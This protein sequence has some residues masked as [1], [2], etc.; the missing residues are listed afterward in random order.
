[1]EGKLIVIIYNSAL[2]CPY[3]STY[4]FERQTNNRWPQVNARIKTHPTNSSSNMQKWH[5]SWSFWEKGREKE[6]E[7]GDEESQS[8]W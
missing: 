3:K 1:M 6:K 7:T 2:I 4:S 5:T 8:L